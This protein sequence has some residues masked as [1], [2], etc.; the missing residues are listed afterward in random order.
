MLNGNK[1]GLI[2]ERSVR[3]A[4]QSS[5]LVCWKESIIKPIGEE[6]MK[7]EE[8]YAITG[9]S[10]IEKKTMRVNITVQFIDQI[11]LS[12]DV[13]SSKYRY[14]RRQNWRRY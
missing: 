13:K 10:N 11:S 4:Q 3:I 9:P 5:D 8:K 12:N 14:F 7:C 1:E 6:L 2:N